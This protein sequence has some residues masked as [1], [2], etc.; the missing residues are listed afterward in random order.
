MDTYYI[1]D[2]AHQA[3]GP[4]PGEELARLRHVGA[5]TDD[6]LVL[7]SGSMQWITYQ[8]AA[9]LGNLPNF[10]PPGAVE[11]LNL[12]LARL[13]ER[14]DG[15]IDL[16][17][18]WPGIL[19]QHRREAFQRHLRFLNNLGQVGLLVIGTLASII[20]TLVSLKFDV[21]QGIIAGSLLV[22]ATFV[23]MYL[24][25]LLADANLR[26]AFGPPI[27]LF[28]PLVPRLIT[29][30]A[31]LL[32]V[33]LLAGGLVTLWDTFESTFLGGVGGLLG[34]AGVIAFLGHLAWVCGHAAE[35]MQVSYVGRDEQSSA[36][37]VC[38]LIRFSGRL[39]LLLLP[40]SS[41]AGVAV[42]LTGG[43]LL[44]M[45]MGVGS[46]LL[47]WRAA[48]EVGS[49]ALLPVR[50]SM[51]LLGGGA[52]PLAPALLVLGA[53]MVGHLAGHFAYLMLTLWAEIGH[54]FFRGVESLQRLSAQ[55]ASSSTTAAIP[56]RS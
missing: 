8:D 39:L 49:L 56:P 26:L 2:A 23:V 30:A 37:Y 32:A 34:L 29:L 53:P 45:Q 46:P 47:L 9:D 11:R 19:P 50:Q 3:A 51:Q 5:L 22:P 36:D 24:S 13:H 1:E 20:T 25:Q 54:G 38:N 21:S 15:L 4:F 27:H 16:L 48:G 35:V 18:S 42:L 17:L 28:S 43:A 41:C 31:L 55:P 14:I 44:L 12:R 40:V 6:S 10:S 7:P 33:V 52:L